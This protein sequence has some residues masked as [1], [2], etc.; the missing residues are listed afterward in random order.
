MK[1][2]MNRKMTRKGNTIKE[3]W[4]KKTKTKKD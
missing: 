4:G 1:A 3:K 2:K